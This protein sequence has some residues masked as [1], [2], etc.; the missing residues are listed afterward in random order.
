MKDSSALLILVLVLFLMSSSTPQPLPAYPYAPGVGP[1]VPPQ[2]ATPPAATQIN[3]RNPNF[4]ISTAS[5]LAAAGTLGIGSLQYLVSHPTEA[6]GIVS[7]LN[8][9]SIFSS[10][11]SGP[12]SAA[13]TG[14]WR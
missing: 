1:P 10:S 13:H 3:N 6:K 14:G 12:V 2:L 7:Q 5:P 9:F 8:P 11:K 4:A